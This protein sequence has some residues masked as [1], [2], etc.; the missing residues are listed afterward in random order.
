MR[1]T[2]RWNAS[3][4]EKYNTGL[5][6]SSACQEDDKIDEEQL[7]F[8]PSPTW[9]SCHCDRYVNVRLIG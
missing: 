6:S 5:L 7:A 1:P 8:F 4:E 9:K 3:L 2:E